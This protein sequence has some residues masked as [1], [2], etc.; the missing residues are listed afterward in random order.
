ML[1]LEGAQP[2][3][4][5][6]HPFFGQYPAITRNPFGKG[7]LTYEGTV[8]SLKLQEGV[9]REVLKLAGL[10][11]PDQQ[12][13]AVVRVKHGVNRQGKTLHYYLNYSSDPQTF[14]YPYGAG[15]DLLTQAGIAPSQPITLTPWDLAIIEEK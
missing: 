8:L 14:Q 13:P 9:L 5:Y 12:L 11:G 4:Y 15:I 3:A 10:A 6:E 7:T 1:I 2:L